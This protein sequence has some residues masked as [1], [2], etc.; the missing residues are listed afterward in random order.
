[1]TVTVTAPVAPVA[2]AGPNQTVASGTPV[3]TLAGSATGTAPLTF[4][5]TQA[6]GDAPN[7]VTLS[8]PTIA[9]P[10]FAAPFVAAPTTLHFTLTVTNAVGSSSAS[11]T[12]TVNAVNAPT[13]NPIPNITVTSGATNQSFAVSGTDTSVPSALP[14]SFTATQTGS[15][16]LIGLSTSNGPNPPGTGGTVRFSA[17]TLAAGAPPDVITVS[18]TATNKGNRSSAPQTMTVTVVSVSAPTVNHVAPISVFSGA[19]GSLAISGTDPNTPASLPLTFAVTQTGTPAL[20]NL[21]VAQGPNPPGTAATVTFKAPTLPVG[22]VTSV[23][24]NLT[25]TATNKA[26]LVSAPEFTSVTVKPLADTVTITTAAYRTGKQ[27][28][29]LTAT[30]SV[31]SP[32]V[33]LTLQPY[34]TNT[35]TTFTPPNGTFTNTGGGIYTITLVGAPEPKIP[36]ATPLTVKSNLGGISAPTAL[37][38]IKK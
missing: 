32:T 5:W 26:G 16:A 33:V 24:I 35:G 4:A 23:V 12:V 31:I 3:V 2:N 21:A 6:A 19:S 14:L 10:T 8:D 28:L 1:M 27:R 36:P 34:V 20:T 9:G 22:Q 29:D 25:I 7:L 18:V 15:P 11:M 37:T 30:S 38:S 17:P 13:V